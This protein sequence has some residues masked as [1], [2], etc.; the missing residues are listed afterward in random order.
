MRPT[1]FKLKLFD[2][3]HHTEEGLVIGPEMALATR[4]L[5]VKSIDV[6]FD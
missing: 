1:H 5:K 4:N 3:S 6:Y 2:G